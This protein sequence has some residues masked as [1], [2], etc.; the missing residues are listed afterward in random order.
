M[1]AF[2]SDGWMDVV[3]HFGRESLDVRTFQTGW[4]IGYIDYLNRNTMET[5]HSFAPDTHGLILQMGK[6]RFVEAL[7]GVPGPSF[8]FSA[9]AFERSPPAIQRVFWTWSITY[10]Y[11]LC[12]FKIIYQS[13]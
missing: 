6:L 2:P 12:I 7:P 10:K 9:R 5:S 3:Y 1:N 13:S 4:I 11:A 8:A